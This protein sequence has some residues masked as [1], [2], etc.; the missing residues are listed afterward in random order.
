MAPVLPEDVLKVC[1]GWLGE[2]EVVSA[3][4]VCRRWLAAAGDALQSAMFGYFEP[5][6]LKVPGFKDATAARWMRCRAS[7]AKPED[8]R[9]GLRRLGGVHRRLLSSNPRTT[10]RFTAHC[11]AVEAVYM[12]SGGVLYTGSRDHT[13]RRWDGSWDEPVVQCVDRTSIWSLDVCED[14]GLLVSG[15][16]GSAGAVVWDCETGD[17]L[18]SIGTHDDSVFV[19][20]FLRRSGVLLT[21]SWD[22]TACL[23][24]ID[25]PA[26]LPPEHEVLTRGALHGDAVWRAAVTTDE[27]R[28]AT[29]GW[30]NC[31]RWLHLR[32]EGIESEAK[33][34][35]RSCVTDIE[36]FDDHL[37]WALC[38]SA[39]LWDVRAPQARPML[40]LKPDLSEVASR[41]LCCEKL[42]FLACED[43]AVRVLDM[44]MA[45]ETEARSVLRVADGR[46]TDASVLCVAFPGG[47]QSTS[48]ANLDT[49]ITADFG[50][51]VH[52]SRFSADA[53]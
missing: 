17:R 28:M 49:L 3:S 53:L 25:C 44:R 13:V 45:A 7:D 32:P 16:A 39:C 47:C 21:G 9:R 11:E 20:Q 8:A 22:G 40:T 1:F 48:R 26:G 37:V 36:L 42:V 35:T 15:A 41:V 12:T 24:R 5:C 10:E 46:G 6:I 4:L 19:T 34:Q 29:A 33:L 50:G 51:R 30:D 52:L 14:R 43:G 23:H 38:T 2:A 31:V 18:L 27:T